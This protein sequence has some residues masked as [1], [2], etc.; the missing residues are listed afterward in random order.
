MDRNGRDLS[1]TATIEQH[2]VVKVASDA[3]FRIISPERI[4]NRYER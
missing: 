4:V 3:T 2:G 1:L